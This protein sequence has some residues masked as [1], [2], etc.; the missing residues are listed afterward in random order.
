MHKVEP[1]KRLLEKSTGIGVPDKAD[2]LSR[3]RPVKPRR[4]KFP[5]DGY[6]PNNPLVPLLFYR[7]AVIFESGGDPAALLEAIF[8]ANGWG[9]AW[10]NGIYD[11]VHYHPR[12]HEVLGIAR[13]RATLRLGG[14]M[15]MTVKVRAGDVILVPAGV[16]HEC[17]S[18]DK[19]FLVVGA[20]PPSGTY[21]ECR[22]SFQEYAK[23]K[24]QVRRVAKP[25]KNPLFG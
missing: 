24:E 15:G 10:R 12:I 19:S 23:A 22:G 2:A 7:R 6:I 11:F 20:Y 13:G 16:G 1:I 4:L 14:N 5:A 9:D 18:A 21:S 25:K 17:L 8:N 3:I